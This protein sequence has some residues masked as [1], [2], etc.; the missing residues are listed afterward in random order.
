[1]IYTCC[2]STNIS[3][4]VLGT[5]PAPRFCC[6]EVGLVDTGGDEEYTSDGAAGIERIGVAEVTP[7]GE[8]DFTN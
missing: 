7:S 2:S 6:P 8:F 1:M 3:I 5:P 4:P